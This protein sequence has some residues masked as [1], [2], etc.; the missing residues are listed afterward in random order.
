MTSITRTLIATIACICV[1]EARAETESDVAT[2][3]AP[4][5]VSKLGEVTLSPAFSPDGKTAYFSRAACPRVWQCPQLLYKSEQIG[6]VWQDATRFADLGNYRVDWPGVSPDGETLIFTWTAPQ[7]KYKGLDISENF[8]LFTLDL[9][10]TNARPVA[11]EGADINRPRA[12][13]LKNRR[14]F[15]VQSAGTLTRNGDLYFW[16]ERA[17]AVG[18][19]DVFLARSDGNGGF[20]KAEPLPAPINSTGRDQLG[21]IN[22][23]G[24]VMLLAYPDRGGEGDDDIFISRNR[25]GVWSEPQNLGPLVNSSAYDA[26]ARFTPD[27]EQLVF[28]SSRAFDGEPEGLLQVWTIP[29]RPLIEAGVLEPSDV[30]RE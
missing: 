21:W 23:T 9:A 5:A 26:G 1:T 27:G 11:I 22:P 28:T 6:G 29:T 24:T 13:V 15:H 17:D 16:D 10:D 4:G 3:F 12:G 20:M 25:D 8:D 30:A 19:R 18:E 2:R 7:E 14:A